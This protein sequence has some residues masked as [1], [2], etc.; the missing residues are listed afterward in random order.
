MNNVDKAKE[1]AEGKI[2]DALNK[3]IV[4]AYMA[5]YNSGYQD[6]Y[7][8][9]VKET[10]S[11]DI[12]YVDLG[13][14]SGTL[15]SSNYLEDENNETVYVLQEKSKAFDIPTVEQWHELVREC[16]WEQK[17]E[18]IDDSY[19]FYH[20]HDWAICLGPNGN[21]IIFEKTGLYEI[22]TEKVRTNEVLFWLKKGKNSQCNS[23]NITFCTIKITSKN[24]F[25]GYRL[26]I[27]LVKNV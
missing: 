23:A 22:Q 8:K 4:E 20:Y 1:Y 7:D 25:S 11:D 21:R 26:P 6:G 27:R 14:P 9:V 15:W 16:R 2:N 19:G 12:E 17:S 24:E 3:V 18:R 13:L 10:S 5:G